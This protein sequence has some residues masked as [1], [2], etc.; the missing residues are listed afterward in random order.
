M[1]YFLKKIIKIAS[2]EGSDPRYSLATG[3]QQSY[4][5]SQP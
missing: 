5:H 4:L 2:F 3:A 1:R